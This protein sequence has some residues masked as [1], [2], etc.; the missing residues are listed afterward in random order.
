MTLLRTT[1]A[2]L[3]TL[4]LGV[5]VTGAALV[6]AAG[7][8]SLLSGFSLLALS[9]YVILCGTCYLVGSSPGRAIATLVVCAIATA[10]AIYFYGR[11][12]FLEPGSM[13]GLVFLLVPFYQLPGAILLSLVMFFIRLRSRT[14]PNT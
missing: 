10:G 12:I 3:A 11:L 8:G 1:V 14:S 4:G 7:L 2:S 5:L 6:Q 13:S 9:P